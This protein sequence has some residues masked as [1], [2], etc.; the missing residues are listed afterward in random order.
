[1]ITNIKDKVNL[2]KF[3]IAISLIMLIAVVVLAVVIHETVSASVMQPQSGIDLSGQFDSGTPEGVWS[4][5][6]TELG[7]A[8]RTRPSAPSTNTRYPYGR[9]ARTFGCWTPMIGTCTRTN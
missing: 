7:I 3:T 5:C 6:R 1:M 2:S 8:T 9:T 4:D